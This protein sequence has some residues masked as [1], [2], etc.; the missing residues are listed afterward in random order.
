MKGPVYEDYFAYSKFVI[1]HYK[2]MMLMKQSLDIANLRQRAEQAEAQCS[3]KLLNQADLDI[4]KLK[5]EQIQT[6]IHELQVHQ[7]E[8][9]MQND[10]LKNTQQALNKSQT[11]YARIYNLAPVAYLTLSLQ[12]TILQANL[13][14][15]TLLNTPLTS[16]LSQ[17]LDN[18]IHI[19]DQDAYYLFFVSCKM[20]R[21]ALSYLSESRSLIRLSMN[22]IT[23][24]PIFMNMR[25]TSIQR[26]Q[27]LLT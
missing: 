5:P 27:Y 17:R 7:I 8:L 10:E 23:K 11:D 13:A 4:T 2:E 1:I 6:L 24:T 25:L 22:H 19:D 18:F 21:S 26:A 15:T 12:R 3:D 9:E 16:L 20:N 14:A